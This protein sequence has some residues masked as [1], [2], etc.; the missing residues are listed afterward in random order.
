MDA[1]HHAQSAARA[2]GGDPD[3]YYPIERFIDQSKEGSVGD[4]RHRALLHHTEGIRIVI[5][6]FGSTLAVPR[7]NGVVRVP[8]RRIAERHILEDVGWLPSH[9]DWLGDTPIRA[10]MSGSQ[11][12]QVPLSHLL[13]RAP[14]EAA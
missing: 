2:F 8:L 3:L 14:G 6:V 12:K 11:R 4:V 9:K 5:E 7:T 13:L 10:W 1:W